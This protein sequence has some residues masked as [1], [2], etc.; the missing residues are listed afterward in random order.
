[1]QN[2]STVSGN[3]GKALIGGVVTFLGLYGA[4][5]ISLIPA[6][7][8]TMTIGGVLA[9]IIGFITHSHATP[10]GSTVVRKV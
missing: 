6:N 5:L 2:V 1:M 8:S 4:T 10:T 9:F 3:V 7:I